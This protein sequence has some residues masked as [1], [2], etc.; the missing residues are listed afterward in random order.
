MVLK[1]LWFWR[2]RESLQLMGDGKKDYSKFWHQ[3]IQSR[4]QL[5]QPDAMQ[6][7]AA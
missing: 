6:V 3:A 2:A 1:Q 4:S 5:S 7:P